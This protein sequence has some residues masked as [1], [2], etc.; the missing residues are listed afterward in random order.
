ML[1]TDFSLRRFSTRGLPERERVRMWREEFGRT[2]LRV[3]IEPLTNLPFYADAELRAL[4][5]VRLIRGT[6]SAVHFQRTRALV[7]DGDD[8]ISIIVS[9]SC[10]AS[11]RGRDVVL[12][13]GGSVALLGREPADVAF[14][15]G[16]RLTLFVP[17]AALAERA[18]NI[19]DLTLHPV[20]HSNQ[21]LGLL[22]RYLTLLRAKGVSTSP[23]VR[24]AVVSHIH[25]LIALA[26]GE[27]A[28]LGE[29]NSTAAMAARLDVAL[30]YI[31]AHFQDPEFSLTEAAQNLRISPPYLQRLLE[32]SGTSFTARVTELR[33]RR[34][35][36]LLAA[37]DEERISDIAMKAGFSDISYF[38]RVFR[39]HFD[40][41]PS[42]ARALARAA[43]CMK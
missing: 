12:S 7:A 18:S 38:N 30:D 4:P 19:D 17:R 37:E 40:V 34:A 26:L 36:M 31:A 11:Q 22:L 23:K 15:E 43:R 14:A 6:S 32:T 29:S 25:D 13:G 10:M 41:T 2:L 5:G 24:D 3:H 27:H 35:F 8:S 9:K 28:S 39:S 1:A 20:P 16:S 42:D 33:L 21:A